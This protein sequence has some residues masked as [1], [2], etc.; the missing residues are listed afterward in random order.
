MYEMR[1][2]DVLAYTRAETQ[3]LAEH[4]RMKVPIADRVLARVE[5]VGQ[6]KDLAEAMEL[7]RTALQKVRDHILAQ[8]S[9]HNALGPLTPESLMRE[10][11]KLEV[12]AE[13]EDVRGKDFDAKKTLKKAAQLKRQAKVLLKVRRT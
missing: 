11:H 1:V 8:W 5:A 10:V 3:K 6:A 2:E 12:R 13:R 4:Y 7:S 9:Q